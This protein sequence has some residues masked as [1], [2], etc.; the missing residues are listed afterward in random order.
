MPSPGA[1]RD[2]KSAGKQAREVRLVT[3]SAVES[4]LRKRFIRLGDQTLGQIQTLFL[5]IFRKRLAEACFEGP[6]KMT[7]AEVDDPGDAIPVQSSPKVCGY[8]SGCLLLLPDGKTDL[9]R[10]RGRQQRRYGREGGSAMPLEGGGRQKM[11]EGKIGLSGGQG[12]HRNLAAY[13]DGDAFENVTQVLR[14]RVK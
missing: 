10:G 14:L 13:R 8:V 9:W 6:C 1:R 5:D 2:F 7:D 4:D 11:R 12:G 3:K